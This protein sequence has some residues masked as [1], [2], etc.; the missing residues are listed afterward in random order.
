MISSGAFLT[1]AFFFAPELLFAF[2][3]NGA[4]FGQQ[5]LNSPDGVCDRIVQE[6]LFVARQRR[7][8]A[9]LIYPADGVF[10]I[11][12]TIRVQ[13]N[14]L[15]QLVAIPVKIYPRFVAVSTALANVSAERIIFLFPALTLWHLQSGQL[16]THAIRY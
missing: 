5:L 14:F 15:C 4:L 1:S 6:P 3:D 7:K 12:R 2:P 16:I 11:W 8:A 13:W 9:W 10:I